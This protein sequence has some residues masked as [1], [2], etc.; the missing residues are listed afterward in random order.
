MSI[1]YK[2]FKLNKLS[3]SISQASKLL[4]LDRE[5]IRK[6][7]ETGDLLTFIPPGRIHRRIPIHSLID[8]I[9]ENSINISFI[10]R[11]SNEESES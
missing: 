3:L 7:I 4:Q 9:T 2:G 11:Y 5:Y 10:G 6:R 8:F 1:A